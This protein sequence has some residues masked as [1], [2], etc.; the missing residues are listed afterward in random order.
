MVPA[1]LCAVM[2]LLAAP[3][4]AAEKAER[5]NT[6]FSQV[7]ALLTLL[8]IPH[9]NTRESLIQATQLWRRKPG[10][11]RWEMPDVTLSP[12]KQQAVLALLTDLGVVNPRAPRE[13]EYDYV[14]VLG[15]TVPAM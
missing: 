7:D 8:D 1:F 2:L 12:A 5:E 6:P 11:E 3:V 13:Q 10:I 9:E 14:L 4:A 15:A